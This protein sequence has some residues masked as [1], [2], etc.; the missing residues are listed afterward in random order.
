[1]VVVPTAEPSVQVTEP[2]I[3]YALDVRLFEWLLDVPFT[4]V[5]GVAEN[6]EPLL[7]VLLQAGQA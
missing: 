1:M 6:G 2:L 4:N 7:S 3:W 5:G